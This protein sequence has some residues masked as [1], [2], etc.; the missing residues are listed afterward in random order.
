MGLFPT[1]LGSG[2]A[3][4]L[5]NA[6]LDVLDGVTA[7][8]SAASKAVVLGATSKIDTID[9]TALKIN[10]TSMTSTAT[11]L[12][13]LASSGVSNADL[14]KLH[15]ITATAA[16]L[17]NGVNYFDH[18]VTAA[19]VKAC[20]HVIVPGITGKQFFPTFAAMVATGAVTTSTHITLAESVSAGVVLSHVAADM[21]DGVW[22]GPTGG[23]VVT[24]KLNT[25]L[26]VDEGIIIKD[27]APNS[28]TI[29]TAIRVIVGGYYV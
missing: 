23:T 25:A 12:N 9:M 13:T 17:N 19:E 8:T 10:G 21:G 6:E 14:V 2:A 20:N 15:A 29:T 24:T 1:W 3:T 18:T 11:E 5:T 22:A 16:N 27:T 28:L 26:T 7:G 4:R